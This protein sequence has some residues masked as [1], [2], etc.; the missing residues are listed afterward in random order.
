MPSKHNKYN[1]MN[2]EEFFRLANSDEHLFSPEENGFFEVHWGH[3]PNGG[4]L[5]IG[6]FFDKYGRPCKR[7]KM[8]YM[9]ICEYLN[10]GTLVQSTS[11][12][13][14]K[15]AEEE[16]RK[17]QIM[18]ADDYAINN[19]LTVVGKVFDENNDLYAKCASQDRTKSII[20]WAPRCSMGTVAVIE[21]NF[22]KF[23]VLKLIKGD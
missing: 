11:G 14:P 4:D 19:N 23:Q 9:H 17:G 21:D 5:S 6:S 18:F 3:T 13:P 20:I 7:E 12:T 10:D 16:L 8:A 1:Q 2:D 22:R 15:L